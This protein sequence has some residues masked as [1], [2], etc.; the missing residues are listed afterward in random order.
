MAKKG[1]EFISERSMTGGLR[2]VGPAVI[3]VRLYRRRGGG[4]RYYLD[5][6]PFVHVPVPAVLRHL[7]GV[8][9]VRGLALALLALAAL[10]YG[11]AKLIGGTE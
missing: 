9:V 10:G 4:P 1:T 8:T 2:G 6:V 5:N 11:L 3:R 7:D